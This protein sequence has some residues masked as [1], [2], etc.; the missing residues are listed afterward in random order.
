MKA[1]IAALAFLGFIVASSF[2]T[3]AHANWKTSGRDHTYHSTTNC[4]A[5][6]CQVRHSSKSRSRKL[7]SRM[8]HL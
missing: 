6:A 7:L 4:I 5:G 8:N 2:S 3:S 1:S